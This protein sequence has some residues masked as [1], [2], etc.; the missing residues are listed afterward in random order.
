[1]N[2]NNSQFEEILR[3]EIPLTEFMGIEVFKCNRKNLSLKAPLAPNI[4]HKSTAFGGSLYSLAVLAGWGFL[5]LKFQEKDLTSNIVIHH[6][7]ISYDRPVS[8]EIVATCMTPE[9]KELEKFF[10]TYE[11]KGKAR[12]SLHSIIMQD[13]QTAVTFTGNYVA[14]R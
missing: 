14:H 9:D 11:R 4:N 2:N 8:G 3:H 10:T 1:L 7:H 13:M 12:I 5:Y 6:S